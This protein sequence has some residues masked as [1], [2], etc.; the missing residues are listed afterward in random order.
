LASSSSIGLK[1]E[2]FSASS[3]EIFLSFSSLAFQN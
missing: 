1:F 3:F 2:R